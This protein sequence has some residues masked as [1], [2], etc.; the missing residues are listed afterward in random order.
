VQELAA[1]A[2]A[3]GALADVLT[4]RQLAEISPARFEAWQA[5]ADVILAADEQTSAQQE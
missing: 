4:V 3:T 5:E 2:R 1:V